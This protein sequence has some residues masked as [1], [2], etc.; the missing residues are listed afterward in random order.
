MS[1]G[2]NDRAPEA[3]RRSRLQ[4][5]GEEGGRGGTFYIQILIRRDVTAAKTIMP[6]PAACS[7]DDRPGGVC[8]RVMVGCMLAACLTRWQMETCHL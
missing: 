5:M 3:T 7:A 6:G 8:T 4:G 2:R 1:E